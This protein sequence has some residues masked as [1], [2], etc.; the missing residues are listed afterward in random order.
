MTQ[1][2][3]P[4]TIEVTVA[5]PIDAVWHSLRDH[6]AIRRWHGW[7]FD[8]LDAEITEIYGPA[9]SEP[10]PYELLLDGGDRF[11]LAVEGA[12]TR[13]VLT[14][15]PL[16]SDPPWDEWYEDINEGWTTF[17]QQL[18]FGLERHPGQDRRTLFLDAS[19]AD[20][21]DPT[22]LLRGPGLPAD[23]TFWFRSEHQHGLTLD[24]L[25]PGL[26]IAGTKPVRPGSPGGAMAIVTAYG[27]TDAEWTAARDR[28]VVWWRG[29]YPGAAEPV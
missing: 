13:V 6:A 2:D 20:L 21:P 19:G 18:K 26:V 4:V 12:T 5:A 22:A 27:L 24:P 29:H 14:R 15:A 25:G 16:G 28:W 7:D 11:T 17:L 10:A 23:G 8:G 9:A 1:P 3:S